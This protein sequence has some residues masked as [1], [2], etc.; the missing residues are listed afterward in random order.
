MAK[1]IAIVDDEKDILELLSYS[2]LKEGFQV[3]TFGDGHQALKAIK[4]G[5]FDLLILDLMLPSM[6]GLE[7]CRAVKNDVKTASLPIV[8]LTAK[9]DEIDRVVG[10]EMGADDYITKP[11]SPRELIARVRAVLRRGSGISPAARVLRIGDIEISREACTVFKKGV[12]IPLS[13]TEFRL[14]L[15]LTERPGRVFTR[16][17]LLDSVW[18][19]ETFV[20]PRTVD[21]HIRRLRTQIEDNPENP[22]YIKTKRGIGYYMEDAL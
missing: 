16:E 3:T 5:S 13:A 22:K 11:F 6:S 18:G 4:R 19:N 7:V 12:A 10:L 15:S 14:L 17:M 20:E 1:R 2:L 9:S 21:V 8:M